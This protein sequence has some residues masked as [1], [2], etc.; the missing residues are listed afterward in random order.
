MANEE[1]NAVRAEAKARGVKWSHVL[2]AYELVKADE[3][4]ARA[5]DNEVRRHAWFVHA[6]AT[7]PYWAR[8]WSCGFAHVYGKRVAESDYKAIP[9]YDVTH[10]EVAGRFPEF[11]S[12]DGCERLWAFLLSPYRPMPRRAVM[13]EKA[14]E[15]VA[16][17]SRRAEELE[18]V[19]F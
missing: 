14:V 11:A 17:E 10:Q 19:P 9:G 4:E 3:I 2:E 12:D 6:V 16:R 8:F 18:A 15:L 7:R 1:I 13:L 5:H